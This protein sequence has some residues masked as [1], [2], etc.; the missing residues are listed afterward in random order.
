M[1][2]FVLTPAGPSLFPA[3]RVLQRCW[4]VGFGALKA[5]AI[6]FVIISAGI[7]VNHSVASAHRGSVNGAAEMA[8]GVGRLVAP[9]VASPLFAWSVSSDGMSIFGPFTV[10]ILNALLAGLTLFWSTRMPIS[11]NQLPRDDDG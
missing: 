8:S 11:I 5:T 2:A 6:E 9:A 3:D 10:F 1:D 7:F 4:F